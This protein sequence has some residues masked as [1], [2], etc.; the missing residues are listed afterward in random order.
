MAHNFGNTTNFQVAT[1]DSFWAGLS[2]V[3][4]TNDGAD[5]GANGTKYRLGRGFP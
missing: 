2:A 5:D 1:S 3:Q 4:Q